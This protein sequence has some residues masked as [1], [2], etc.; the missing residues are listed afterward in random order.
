MNFNEKVW[1]MC[2]RIPKG[3]MTTYKKD[4]FIYFLQHM[5]INEVGA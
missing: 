2:K 1:K 3:E 5:L 4:K